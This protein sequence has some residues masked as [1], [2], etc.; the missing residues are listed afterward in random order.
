MS[1]LNEMLQDNGAFTIQKAQ[2]RGPA[3]MNNSH[4]QLTFMTFRPI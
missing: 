4:S 3:V 1:S 2:V